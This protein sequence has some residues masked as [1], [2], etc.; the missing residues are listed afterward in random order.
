MDYYCSKKFTDL[1]V[2]VQSRLLYNCCKAY[3]ERINLDW[4][5]KNPGQLF[6]TKTMLQDRQLMLN[7]KPCDSCDFGCYKYE[8]Q[9]LPSQRNKV[10][11]YGTITDIQHP[12]KH[13]DIALST[14]CNLTCLYCDPEFSTS[15]HKDIETNGAY[16]LATRKTTGKNWATLW[17]K[18]KQKNR[19]TGTKFFNLLLT[20]IKLA[21][22]LDSISIAGGEPLLNNNIDDL[23][24]VAGDKKITIITGLGISD[25]RLENFLKKYK[26]KNII[27]KVSCETT[28]NYFEFLR[29]GNKWQNFLQ[30]IKKISDHNFKI[31]FGAT[32]TNITLLDFPN[33]YDMFGK[34]YEIII[35]PITERPFLEPYVLDETS[36]S[37]FSKWYENNKQFDKFGMMSNICKPVA[38][39]LQIKD[40]NKFILEFCKRRNIDY[41]FLPKHFL[42]WLKI[43]S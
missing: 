27:F 19:S 42:H 41:T 6:Y 9:G 30:K 35:N 20:E 21:K 25:I 23:V 33:F 28:G 5:E 16:D 14:D 4:L 2:H 43:S 12:L 37:N 10:D 8:R 3:P 34:D 38:S 26:N 22:D 39:K 31:R 13:L 17:A 36:K 11:P 32:I 7:D 15:W 18:M 29:Y 1:Y 40:L 24:K